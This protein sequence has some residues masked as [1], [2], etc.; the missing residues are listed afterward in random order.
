MKKKTGKAFKTLGLLAIVIALLAACSSEGGNG[1][2]SPAAG[3]SA[4][5]Q[6]GNGEETA[7]EL[8][9]ITLFVDHPWWPMTEWK[10]KIPEEITKRTGIKVNVQIAADAQQLPL[11]IASG[12]QM[13][14]IVYTYNNHQ[15][16]SNPDISYTWDELIDQY[17]LQDFEIAPIV[18]AVNA[19][20]DGRLYTVRN[21]FMTAEELAACD[22]CLNPGQG[23]SVRADIMEALG[24]PKLETLEDYLDILGQVKAKYP[25]LIPAVIT[26]GEAGSYLRVQHGVPRFSFYNAGDGAKYYIHH[27]D[28]EAFY[29]YV[30]KL[31]REGYIVAENFTWQERTEAE[32]QILNGKAFSLLN[33]SGDSETLNPRLESDGKDFRMTQVV[34]N[35]GANAK[36]YANSIGWSGMYVPKTA[37]NTEAAIKFI[38]YMYSIEGQRLASWGI[39]GED[40]TMHP[41]GYPVFT[42]DSKDQDKQVQMGVVWWGILADKGETSSLQ[43]YVPDSASTEAML[44]LK[45]VTEVDSLFG[46]VVPEADSNEQVIQANIDNMIKNEEMKIYLAKSEDDAKAAFK[47]ML[48]KARDIGIER[49]EEWATKEYNEAKALMK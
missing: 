37:K 43:R 48:D 29:L 10:G 41:D 24:N 23:L 39:E 18:R 36:V 31:Y 12:A 11:M 19:T 21:G 30:N 28:Q 1:P 35:L 44:E 2:S 26:P 45:K 42:F 3:S 47:A 8:G 33:A 40:W 17:Q 9:E 27:P 15:S 22:K 6:T 38:Q 34:K 5:A 32:N 25:D 4:P 13:P 20:K 14:D 16:M 49:L 7:Q 46:K